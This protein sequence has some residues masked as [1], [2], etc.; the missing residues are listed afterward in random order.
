MTASVVKLSRC[1]ATMTRLQN[2]YR[3]ALASNPI[4]RD[5]L[6]VD[7]SISGEFMGGCLVPFRR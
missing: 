4:L 7:C 5:C 3:Q 2:C 1:V 6:L